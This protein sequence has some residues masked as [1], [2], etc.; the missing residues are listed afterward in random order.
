MQVLQLSLE[1]TSIPFSEVVS[2]SVFNDGVREGDEGFV[3]ILVAPEEG[4]A[5]EDV[6]FV[7]FSTQVIVISLRDG[8]K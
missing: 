8:G 3:V 5:E 2:I 7:R 4:L 6:G 1:N